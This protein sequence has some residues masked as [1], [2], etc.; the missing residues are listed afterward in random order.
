MCFHCRSVHTSLKYQNHSFSVFPSGA[1]S[2]L[3]FELV[4]P[5]VK[6]STRLI[7]I[8][9]LQ[10][11]QCVC[12]CSCKLQIHC[13]EC[14]CLQLTHLALIFNSV[15]LGICFSGLT[16]G[17]QLFSKKNTLSQV[18]LLRSKNQQYLFQ[19]LPPKMFGFGLFSPIFFVCLKVDCFENG[20]K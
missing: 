2:N 16:K 12:N 5:Y 6:R 20:R 18:S 15:S 7:D 14:Y 9:R 8:C 1:L 17:K 13:I 19:L 10:Y 3:L 11:D 4:R